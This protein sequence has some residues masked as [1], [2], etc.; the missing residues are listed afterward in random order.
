MD[1][2]KCF[3]YW[4]STGQISEFSYSKLIADSK[5]AQSF[6][7]KAYYD[8]KMKIPLIILEEVKLQHQKAKNL[9]EVYYKVLGQMPESTVP[10][11]FYVYSEWVEP[12]TEH[13][14]YRDSKNQLLA[15]VKKK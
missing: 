7:D 14:Y 11:T 5:N 6:R 3:G 13:S 9:A 12:F 10:K 1:H 4:T 15:L 2:K 8:A